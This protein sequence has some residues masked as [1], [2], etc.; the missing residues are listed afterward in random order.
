MWVQFVRATMV[1]GDRYTLYSKDTLLT[2]RNAERLLRAVAT[3]AQK[4]ASSLAAVQV[5]EAS[6][7]LKCCCR[8]NA[9]ILCTALASN[10]RIV[11]ASFPNC[12]AIC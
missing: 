10:R 4:S 1:S 8:A 11:W 9:C 5:N 2:T 6:R 12:W 3:P 7:P